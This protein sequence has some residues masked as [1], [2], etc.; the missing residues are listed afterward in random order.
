MNLPLGLE[1]FVD[2]SPRDHALVLAFGVL[3]CL[4]GYVG[5]AALFF[6]FGA[7]D[8]GGPA[9]PRRVASVF[10]SMACW[11]V[12]AVAFVRGKGGPVTDVLAYP[13]ATVAAVPFAARWIAFGPAWGALRERLGF[14]LFRPDLLADAAAL[15]VPGI[16]L[17]ASL[18]TLWASRLDETEVRA[19]Q[20]RNLSAEFREAFVDE[21]DFEG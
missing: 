14:F 21:A 18:L 9:A 15:V 6:G 13:I 10:A 3:A 19:W 1:P 2:Q 16:A 12:Y 11:A 5:S 17:C 20:R 8:H 7:L 4:V